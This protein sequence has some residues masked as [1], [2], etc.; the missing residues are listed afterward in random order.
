MDW[1]EEQVKTLY[2]SDEYILKNPSLHEKDSPWKVSTIVPMLDV[3]LERWHAGHMTVLDVGG[4]AGLILHAVCKYLQDSRD[5]EIKKFALDLSPGMLEIQRKAN[6][7]LAR[8]LNEDIRRTSLDNRE[9]DLTL[10]VDV[11]EHVPNPIEALKEIRRV[12]EWVILKVPLENNFAYNLWNLLNGGRPRRRAIDTIGHV[13]SYS[14]GK[15]K[16]EVERHTGEILSCSYAN[17][18]QYFLTSEH[19]RTRLSVKGKL[20]HWVGANLFRVSPRLCALLLGGHLIMLVKCR[21]A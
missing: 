15:L 9:V 13:N 19:A 6:P 11:L 10:M 17:V 12:S 18:F 1:I 8:T 14:A 21:E 7:D 4:G 2:V 20:K 16:K 5:I 3:F